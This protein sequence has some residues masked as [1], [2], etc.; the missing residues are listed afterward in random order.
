[1]PKL[2][3]TAEALYV[4]ERQDIDRVS[5]LRI[6]AP[7]YT[8]VNVGGSWSWSRSVSIY[9]RIENVLNREY[10]P[11]SGFQALGRGAFVGLRGTI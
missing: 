9:A 4:G 8:V 5:G 3:F 10:E 2:G 6:T 1:M 11:A 7:D